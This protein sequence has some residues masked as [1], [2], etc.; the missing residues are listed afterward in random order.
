[1]GSYI[2]AY[3]KPAFKLILKENKLSEFKTGVITLK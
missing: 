2:T 3:P 1:L